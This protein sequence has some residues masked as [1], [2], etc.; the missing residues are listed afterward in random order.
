M[1]NTLAYYDT[2]TITAVKIFIVQ[3]PGGRISSSVTNGPNKLEGCHTRQERLVRDKRSSL[4]GPLINYK[5]NEFLW[6]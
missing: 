6:K 2:V 1:A 3:T 5:E 4:F